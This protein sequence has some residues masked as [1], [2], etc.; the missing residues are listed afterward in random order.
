MAVTGLVPA[1]AHDA[2]M[3]LSF[4]L[5]ENGGLLSFPHTHWLTTA[6]WQKQGMADEAGRGL[7]HLHERISQLSAGNLAWMIL[8][9]RGGGVD[10][11]H[12]TVTA[13]LDRLEALRDPAGHWPSDEGADNAVH[14][15]VEAIQAMQLG[16]RLER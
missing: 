6:L 15:T 3:Y 7:A 2:A 9:L 4:H 8:T 10:A 5:D 14:V 1:A 12:E 13:A 16:G 11:G